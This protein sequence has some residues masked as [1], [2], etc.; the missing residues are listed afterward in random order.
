MLLRLR[1]VDYVE[2]IIIIMLVIVSIGK[3]S[4]PAVQRG[5]SKSCRLS[6]RRISIVESVE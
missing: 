1:V 2:S 4:I 6:R 3:E 5:C